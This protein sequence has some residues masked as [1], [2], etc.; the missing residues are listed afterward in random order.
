[1]NS[2]QGTR[3]VEEIPTGF[4]P[5]INLRLSLLDT[6][7]QRMYAKKIPEKNFVLPRPDDHA[8][9]LLTQF[10]LLSICRLP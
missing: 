8:R 3:I 7:L 2:S 6:N 4:F 10:V 5:N 9:T 1:M